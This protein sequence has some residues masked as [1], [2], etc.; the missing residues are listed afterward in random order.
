[1]NLVSL[2]SQEN[3]TDFDTKINNCGQLDRRK[4]SLLVK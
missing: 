2:E 1:M 4:K 3:F